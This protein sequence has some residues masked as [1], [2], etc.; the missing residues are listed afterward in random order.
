[1]KRADRLGAKKVLIV[2]DDELSS[3]K[4]V[5][6]DMG[7]KDQQEVRLDNLIDN[8]RKML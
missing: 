6:R 1:M 8:L 3:G 2:G 4:G 5:L 7:T